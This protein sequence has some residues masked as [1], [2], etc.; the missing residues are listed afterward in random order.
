MGLLDIATAYEK[1]LQNPENRKNS[2]GTM[3][4]GK[5][6]MSEAQGVGSSNKPRP[7]TIEDADD[8]WLKEIDKRMATKKG[9]YDKVNEV[10]GNAGSNVLLNEMREIKKMMKMVMDVNL[11]VLERLK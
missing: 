11:K 4:Q 8:R 5:P 9:L 3:K 1:M 7:K 2:S 6:S 10:T